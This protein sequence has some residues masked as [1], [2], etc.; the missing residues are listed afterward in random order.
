METLYFH[1]A[2]WL[3]LAVLAAILATR[4]KVSIAL[5]EICI[6]VV[7]AAVASRFWGANALPN[8]EEWLKFLASSGSVLLT[9]LAGTELEPEVMKAKMK[10]VS[11]VGL[12]G[13]FAPFLGCTA[14]ARFGLGWDPRASWLAGIAL[15]TTSM[16]VVYAVMLET[17]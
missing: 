3:F 7:A 8:N 6:G 11:V 17:G 9:F 13:F 16:A 15:S 5:M 12:V 2:I 4:L 1:A 14:V 10:E